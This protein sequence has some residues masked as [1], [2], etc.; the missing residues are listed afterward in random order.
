VT[1]LPRLAF[2]LFSLART[3]PKQV[4][5]MYIVLFQRCLGTRIRNHSRD[6]SL[7][8][9]LGFTTGLRITFF[10]SNNQVIVRP[11]V[12]IRYLNV[13]IVGSNITLVI[14]EGSQVANGYIWLAGD[15]STMTI[16]PRSY[17]IDNRINLTDSH[18][19]IDI[20]PGCMLGSGAEIRLG[21]GHVLYDIDT[22]RILNQAHHVVLG[23]R[24][25]LAQDVLI[26]KDV[27]IG[28][29]SVIGARSVVTR[30]IPPCSV[31]A[32][33][34]AKVVRSNATWRLERIDDLPVDWFSKPIAPTS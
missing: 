25:W 22:G 3:M 27:E 17:L 24:V 29:D 23:S 1:I 12:E 13:H 2:K 16:G 28:H 11:S 5:F 33:I 18:S 19:R 10:G 6:N 21:D 20:G 9:G 15:S 7:V 32:G 4:Q 30:D 26:L 14:H 34:P 31:A 8:L